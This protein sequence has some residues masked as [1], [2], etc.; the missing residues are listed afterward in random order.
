MIG[1]KEQH[2]NR[3]I[4]A[5]ELRHALFMQHFC[6]IEQDE[7]SGRNECRNKYLILRCRTALVD[8]RLEIR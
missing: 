7:R 5:F 8:A 3:K 2:V 6:E 1:S 4:K